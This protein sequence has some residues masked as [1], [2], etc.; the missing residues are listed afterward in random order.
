MRYLYSLVL[1]VITCLP[2]ATLAQSFK[3][4]EKFKSFGR[5]QVNYGFGLNDVLLDQKANP[6]QIKLTFGKQNENL[7]FG[8]GVATANFRNRGDNGGLNVNTTSFTLNG[9]YVFKSFSDQSSKPFIRIG[10]GY[11]PKIFSEYS[12]GFLYDGSIGYIITNKKGAKY[13]VEAQ[14]QVQYFD[15]FLYRTHEVKAESVGLGIGIWF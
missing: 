2:I 6:F 13:F 14:Y 1:F 10:G 12:K 15:D 5:I 8:I 4:P 9:H 3:T 7:G 11:A